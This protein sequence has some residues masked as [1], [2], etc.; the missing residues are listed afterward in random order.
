MFHIKTRY[1]LLQGIDN[2][3]IYLTSNK[4]LFNSN[5]SSLYLHFTVHNI[6]LLWYGML[7]LNVTP[8]INIK[9]SELFDEYVPRKCIYGK[10]KVGKNINV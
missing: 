4:Y 5:I 7:Y 1:I 10:F 2:Q 3:S 6:T 8:K 9:K